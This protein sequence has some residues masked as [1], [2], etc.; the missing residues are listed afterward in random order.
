MVFK[1]DRDLDDII[2]SNM[3]TIGVSRKEFEKIMNQIGGGQ[4]R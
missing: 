2:F 4:R 1:M 3:R